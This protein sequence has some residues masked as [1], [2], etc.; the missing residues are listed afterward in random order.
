MSEK[1][2]GTRSYHALDWNVEGKQFDGETS[3]LSWKRI[4]EEVHDPGLVLDQEAS[5]LSNQESHVF[6][7][8]RVHGA[9]LEED[10]DDSNESCINGQI[11]IDEAIELL[12]TGMF[13]YKILMSAGLCL[14]ADS[15][16]LLVS[17]FLSIVLQEP[18]Q[19]SNSSM[20]AINS[21][22][23]LGSSLGTIVM[24][25]L[26]DFVLG[27]KPVLLLTTALTCCFG[28]LAALTN[29][30]EALLF[31]RFWV[32]F[33]VGGFTVPF[34]TFAE[35]L[36]KRYRAANLLFIE[37]FWSVGTLLVCLVARLTLV[38][39]DSE[40]AWRWFVGICSIP[41]FISCLASIWHVPESPRWLLIQRKPDESLRIL[42]M[43]A[44]L[45]GKN[46]LDI[47]PPGTTLVQS[48][49]DEDTKK[50]ATMCDLFQSQWRQTTIVLWITWAG[51]TIL[52]YGTILLVT[53]I[54]SNG[55]VKLDQ[56]NGSYS[57]DYNAILA[58]SLSEIVGIT[59]AILLVDRVG[60]IPFQV[61]SYLMGSFAVLSLCILAQRQSSRVWLI[62]AGFLARL[63][64]MSAS[65]TTWVSTAEILPTQ[66]RT[67]GHALANA[68]GRLA[69][70][71]SPFLVTSDHSYVTSGGILWII[72][73]ATALCASRLT[74]TTDQSLGWKKSN[75]TS[76]DGSVQELVCPQGPS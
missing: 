38:R 45:N 20:A 52:T 27:R 17:T 24:G 39:V 58:S 13:Q 9:F 51:Y 53:M 66:L 37:Y 64:L 74:E 16:E 33:G 71:L 5:S 28:L 26:A 1:R 46:A 55:H 49:E 61:V 6:G 32:G 3:A 12:G 43:A 34:D 15:V 67:M 59:L 75:D 23:F 31:C 14:A 42:R 40:N 47:F 10:Q 21:A 62:G 36:P 18:W 22:A 8:E 4:R 50:S 44:K 76:E 65:C 35:F 54:F 7:L 68:I 60:R 73:L 56:S 29:H 2:V 48:N 11:S 63:S 25:Y 41:C 72:G 19:L 69:G 57:F 70:S 30:L